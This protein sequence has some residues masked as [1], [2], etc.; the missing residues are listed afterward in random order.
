MEEILVIGNG[1]DLLHKLPTRY[2]DFLSIIR[3]EDP[4]LERIRTMKESDGRLM[5]RDSA[6]ETDEVNCDELERM[7][8]ILNRNMWAH[9]FRFNDKDLVGWI[10]FEREILVP[11]AM[12]QKL[13]D[14]TVLKNSSASMTMHFSYNCD[15][16]DNYYARVAESLGSGIF[17]RRSGNVVSIAGELVSNKNRIFKE[18]FVDKVIEEWDDFIEAFRIYLREIVEAVHIAKKDWISNLDVKKI[19]SF[20]YSMTERKYDNLSRCETVHVHGTI[21]RKDSIVMGVNMVPNDQNRDFVRFEKFFQR[22]QKQASNDYNKIP[23]DEFLLRIIG[24][25]L[26]EMDF[27]IIKP[28]FERA[29]HIIVHYYN[30]KDRD[31]KLVNMIKMLSRE[32]IEE[33]IY[34]GRIELSPLD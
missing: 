30:R 11:L 28:Y 22:I 23:E 34:N 5:W 4:L 14:I 17:G 9:F 8:E 1:F 7:Y 3:G 33:S 29:S 2:T 13:W 20:N 15:F 18:L 12:F 21:A 25:S 6:I 32:K 24:H 31:I 16:H 10:D 26:D 27:D 19:I